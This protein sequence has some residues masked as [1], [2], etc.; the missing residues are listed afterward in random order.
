MEKNQNC[1]Q[2]CLDVIRAVMQERSVPQLP[3]GVSLGELYDFSR[4]HNVEALVYHGISQ[5]DQKDR[6][7]VLQRWSN[8]AQMLLT[9]SIVQLAERDA[10]FS[11]LED[12]GIA[13][14]PVKGSWLKE[15][16]PQIDFRQMADLDILIHP[17]DR[18]RA[19]KLMLEQGYREEIEENTTHHDA[20]QKKPYMA[21]EMH[22]QLLPN[23][24]RHHGYYQDIWEKVRPEEGFTHLKRL[25]LEDEYIFYILHMQKHM[26]E[27]G[28]GLRPVLDCL[29]YR[30]LR[31]ALDRE[32]LEGEFR[33]LGVW[34]YVLQVEKLA[35]CWFA[36]GEKL[37]EALLPMARSVLWSGT[38]G[39]LENIFQQRMEELKKK[40]KNPV[41]RQAV[42]WISRF[43]RPM[44]EM[45][46]HYPI[47]DRL[48]FLLPVFWVVRIVKKCIL[49]PRALLQHV[50]QIYQEGTKH[51]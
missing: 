17:R 38:Y 50:K 22:L 42:Y 43:C 27:A 31:P 30:S 16:Y 5:L 1:A 51:D 34:E 24:S 12:A 44:E 46:F 26:E 14:L 3:E 39:M 2:Y 4:M 33:K 29:V 47:L 9:Q 21:V 18:E 48:P 13:F 28:C 8:R 36:T 37:P 11:V 6:E 20:Y 45:R 41:M 19:G 40:Y 32:Y 35:D 7:P 10:L 49:K 25:S 23:S 15:Q